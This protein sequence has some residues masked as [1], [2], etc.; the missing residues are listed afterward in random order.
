M[1]RVTE[2]AL[3]VLDVLFL[4]GFE[5]GWYGVLKRQRGPAPRPHTTS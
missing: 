2:V 3:A 5:Q 1:I 4:C